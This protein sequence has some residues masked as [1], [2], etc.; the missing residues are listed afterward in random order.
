LLTGGVY[1]AVT[2]W[3]AIN[4]ANTFNNRLQP[5]R[6]HATSPVPST[7]LDLTYSY[8]QGSG[9]NNGNVV[10]MNRLSSA[11]TATT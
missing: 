6:L 4:W 1:G 3:N 11:Q 2:G 7:L 8:D 5:T 10:Q 9:K